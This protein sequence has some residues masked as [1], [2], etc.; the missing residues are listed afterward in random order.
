MAEET[1][2][3]DF[4]TALSHMRAGAAMKRCAWDKK[5][6][7]K[8]KYSIRISKDGKGFDTQFLYYISDHAVLMPDD[9][10]ANDW[11]TAE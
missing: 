7:T 4:G 11:I 6:R 9:L 8:R 10:L 5:P 3:C 2:G 1:H